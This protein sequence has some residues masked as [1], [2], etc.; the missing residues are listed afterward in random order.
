MAGKLTVIATG[1]LLALALAIFAFGATSSAA[2]AR[3]GDSRNPPSVA[4]IV[5]GQMTG[6][7]G[8][9][10]K[11][12]LHAA[13]REGQTTGS[14]NFVS[15][16]HGYYKG[17][18]RALSCDDGTIRAAGAGTFFRPGWTRVPAV[19]EAVFDSETGEGKVT[20]KARDRVLYTFTGHVDGLIWCGNP[21]SAHRES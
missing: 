6:E 4:A 17:G 15:R 3:E 14:F 20:L 2:D 11:I 8:A 7:H 21:E 12:D 16:G 19:Y 13:V 18:V 9:A 10:A 5:V 1:A